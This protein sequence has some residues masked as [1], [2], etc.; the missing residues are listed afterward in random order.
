MLCLF[1]YFLI[2]PCSAEASSN[3]STPQDGSISTRSSTYSPPTLKPVAT[4]ISMYRMLSD[5]IVLHASAVTDKEGEQTIDAALA[6]L[7]L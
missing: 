6:R 3:S 2:T 7:Q 1:Q 4:H 5:A